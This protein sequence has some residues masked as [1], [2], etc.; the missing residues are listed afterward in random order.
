MKRH[1]LLHS[2]CILFL[3]LIAAA[4]A[5]PAQT[6]T[7]LASFEN[8]RDSGATP[9]FGPLVQ[10]LNGNF[11][12]MT[13]YGGFGSA[14]TIFDVSSSGDL[15]TLYSFCS[16]PQCKDGSTPESGLVLATDGN[17]YGVTYY[18]SDHFAAGEVF[19]VSPGGTLTVLHNFC[20]QLNCTDGRNPVGPLIEGTDGNLY[21]TTQRGGKSDYGTVFK[22]T[23]SGTLTTLYSF[24]AQTN[25][26][27]GS[28]PSGGLLQ[29]ANGNFYGTTLIGG[30][31]Y[32]T[33]FE[34]T[35]T[36][37]L[38]TLH[39]FNYTDGAD[40]EGA[41]IEV[42]GGVFYGTTGGGGYTNSNA[43]EFVGCG[44]IFEITAAG[45][46]TTLYSFCSQENAKG[47]CADGG[48]SYAGLMQATNGKF[49]GMTWLGG[50]DLRGTIYEFTPTAGTIS[51]L[52]SFCSQ[53]NCT[54]GANPF[55]PLLQ[56]TD[57]N[58]YGAAEE[59]G[60]NN[61]GT[62]FQLSL[63]I[64]SFVRTLP[65]SGKVG[66]QVIIL[67]NNLTGT[68]SVSFNGIEASYRVLL[69]TEIK[70]TVPAGATTGTLKVTTPGGALD[71]NV[72]FRV[73]R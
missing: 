25:C 49:Y 6:Y 62:V 3:I 71:S 55:G 24:C 45:N 4:I 26:A 48:N 69:N 40:P 23:P 21:G 19:K 15:T 54:D 33:I 67:G 37:K 65:V 20:S 28:E 11:Y 1:G 16:Q 38:T 51:T 10:G 68:T 52:Y 22:I 43:C 61:A 7:L 63:G 5:A 56:G 35:S 53:T 72:P 58:F 66:A 42:S 47:G 60:I 50:V 36:G 46:L 2:T 31:Y 57:G 18:G 41:L 8:N 70:A 64:G 44:T 12:G 59:G 27:D 39:T 17:F 34:I 13:G 14:G 32:G 9:Y 30:T 73:T 29:A